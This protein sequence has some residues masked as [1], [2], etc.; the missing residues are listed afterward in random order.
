PAVYQR[1]VREFNQ[2]RGFQHP[3]IVSVYDLVQEGNAL[4]CSM[5][6]L[7]GRT[8]R[9]HLAANGPLPLAESVRLLSGVCEALTYAHSVAGH[10]ALS[11]SNIELGDDGVPKLMD[12]GMTAPVSATTRDG[13]HYRAP[14]C[15]E[16]GAE[17]GPAA[18]IWALGFM[19]FEM[20]TGQSPA[21][22]RSV[23]ELRADLPES[24]DQVFAKSL[25]PAE[26]RFATAGEFIAA[27]QKCER[28]EAERAAAEQAT[29]EIRV[30]PGP[31]T[32]RRLIAAGAV[33][34]LVCLIGVVC[35]PFAARLMRPGE[36]EGA[37]APTRNA[38]QVAAPP[39]LAG[40][41]AAGKA[42]PA[43]Y[44][45]GG[46]FDC[47]YLD[48]AANGWCILA[49]QTDF[50]FLTAGKTARDV[51]GSVD[52]E[53]TGKGRLV[54]KRG[55]RAE[56]ARMAISLHFVP[57]RD[58]AE[59]AYLP[60]GN[61]EPVGTSPFHIERQEFDVIALDSLPLVEMTGGSFARHAKKGQYGWDMLDGMLRFKKNRSTEQARFTFQL[62]AI[63]PGLYE[64]GAVVA[65]TDEDA[66]ARAYIDGV[67]VGFLTL[68]LCDSGIPEPRKLKWLGSYEFSAG[69]HTITVEMPAPSEEASS[70]R[71][72]RGASDERTSAYV[73]DVVLRKQVGQ[74]PSAKAWDE[75]I[76]GYWTGGG[77]TS[78]F[79]KAAGGGLTGWF[80]DESH[81][82]EA[83][84]LMEGEVRHADESATATFRMGES[85]GRGMRI[86][87]QDGRAMGQFLVQES[88]RAEF[89][90]RGE[91]FA[92]ERAP[93]QVFSF[94]DLAVAGESPPRFK[95]RVHEP[96]GAPPSGMAR[97]PYQG[98]SDEMSVSFR[99]PVAKAGTHYAGIAF[100]RTADMPGFCVYVDNILVGSVG[101]GYPVYDE[102][103]ALG[104]L[105]DAAGAMSDTEIAQYLRQVKENS[106]ALNEGP[107][108]ETAWLG[109]VQMPAGEHALTI[110]VFRAFEIEPG[111]WKTYTG[112]LHLDHLL[113]N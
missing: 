84:P 64:L 83:Q 29:T 25:V 110:Q 102:Q 51:D 55:A 37:K 91:P 107:H 1:F 54:A 97:L 73:D 79:L 17:P 52:V 16:P 20:L 58:V 88:G 42:S 106:A 14:E 90:D 80:Y 69:D 28:A 43:G 96:L 8:L 78:L 60:G 22:H 41:A 38:P 113:L 44:W 56:S 45:R 95:Q 57:G 59:G 62:P 36:P 10:G 53:I 40:A 67:H 109:Q 7:L 18:D 46:P 49:N 4:L 61:T 39:A 21:G 9:T 70:T 111:A 87:L 47:L 99:M 35:L 77:L 100:Y 27:V 50:L 26:R 19:L 48:A 32:G 81:P 93:L 94:S 6:P 103:A 89:V 105:G 68:G 82:T 23:R 101:P 33:V 13:R 74:S 76:S 2:A 15:R 65:E 98:T 24:L 86:T 3:G 66:E 63:E 72:G 31:G 34:A 5:E 75:Q 85:Y 11:P 92:L 112:A 104:A 108:I 12:F 71:G 30:E